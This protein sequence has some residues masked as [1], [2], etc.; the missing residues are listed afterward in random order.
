MFEKV[1]SD[2]QSRFGS[3]NF[4]FF[5]GAGDMPTIRLSNEYGEAEIMLHGAHVIS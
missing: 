4:N 5:A 3:A 1:I 2:L